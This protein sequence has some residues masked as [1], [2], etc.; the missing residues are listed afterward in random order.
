MSTTKTTVK[1]RIEMDVNI[2]GLAWGP[3]VILRAANILLFTNGIDYGNPMV[4]YDFR[5]QEIATV[6][7]VHEET[8]GSAA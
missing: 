3:S 4:A 5:K 1:L 7:L 8:N 6:K 2:D